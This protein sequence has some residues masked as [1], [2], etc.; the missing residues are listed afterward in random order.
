MIKTGN[1]YITIDIDWAPEEVIEDTLSLLEA[2]DVSATLF[3]THKSMAIDRAGNDRFEKAI[4]PNFN[5]LLEGKQDHGKNA[6]ETIEN[7]LAIYPGAKGVRSHSMAQSSVLLN[8]FKEKGMLYE[9]NHFVPYQPIKPF[10]LWNG[11]IRLPYNWE[12][13]VHFMYRKEFNDDL[14]DFAKGNLLVLDFHPI[15]IFLNTEHEDRYL[16]A[17]KHYQQPKELIPYRNAGKVNKGVRDVFIELLK[18]N[19]GNKN[20]LLKLAGND[21]WNIHQSEF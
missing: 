16:A 20:T 4:H 15:H 17:K 10:F 9:A 21:T 11:L 6:E 14:F 7:L 5:F 8:L 1:C 13:D 19:R 12:D 18:I 2:Y 3:C